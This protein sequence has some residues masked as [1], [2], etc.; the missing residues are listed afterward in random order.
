MRDSVKAKREIDLQWR[1][2]QGCPY[3]VQIK[4]VYENLINNQR[5]LLV[6]MECMLGGELF[7][8]ISERTQPF[9]EQGKNFFLKHV[10]LLFF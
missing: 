4:D 9:T 10:V 8:K 3:I 6:V 5:V 1:A 2:C 7:A